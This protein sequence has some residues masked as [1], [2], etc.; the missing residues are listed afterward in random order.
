MFFAQLEME[1]DSDAYESV[2]MV[3]SIEGHLTIQFRN[4]FNI[5]VSEV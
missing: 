1:L 3:E 4:I 5:D 2:K